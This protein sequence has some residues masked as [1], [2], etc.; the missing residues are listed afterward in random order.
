MLETALRSGVWLRAGLKISLQSQKEVVETIQ[1]SAEE[2]II[3]ERQIYIL[4]CDCL[5]YV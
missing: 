4:L 3:Q 2:V 1:I 5:Y